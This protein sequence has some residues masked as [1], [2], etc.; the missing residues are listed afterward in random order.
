MADLARSKAVPSVV[1][2]GNYDGVH[3]GHKALVSAARARARPEGLRTV[4]LFFDPHPATALS[5]ERAPSQLT[6]AARRTELLRKAGAD[7]VVV[8]CFDAD[9]AR[10]SPAEFV[11]RVL[12]AEL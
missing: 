1:T 10:L 6:T 8:Q 5:P 11:D 7:E 12:V 3:R 9:F 4:A 2:P